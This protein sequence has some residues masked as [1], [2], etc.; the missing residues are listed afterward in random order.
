MKV[1]GVGC[2]M[3][4]G[5]LFMLSEVTYVIIH[6]ASLL[7]QLSYNAHKWKGI[8]IYLGFRSS[9][10]DMIQCKPAPY[11]EAPAS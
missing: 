4:S 6:L 2:K 10:F 7:Q 3:I 9:E 5:E 1:A 8:G 11:I